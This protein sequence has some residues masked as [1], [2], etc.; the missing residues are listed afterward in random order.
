M[1]DWMNAEYI[2]AFDLLRRDG[3]GY[4]EVQ[5][6]ID[7]VEDRKSRRTGPN[8]EFIG[9]AYFRASEDPASRKWDKGLLLRNAHLR[10][11]AKLVGRNPRNATGAVVRLYVEEDVKAF[12]R[13][14]DLI[15]LRPV[16]PPAGTTP[17]RDREEPVFDDLE[18]HSGV[19]PEDLQPPVADPSPASGIEAPHLRRIVDALA[20]KGVIWGDVCLEMGWP[21]EYQ[22]ADVR[23]S[24]VDEVVE[25]IMAAG[26]AK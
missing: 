26:G 8:T 5:L 19:D 20:D 4:K 21:E 11:I 3:G 16:K 12:G 10:V 1:V 7:R 17:G 13:V 22:V 9:V 14:R 24:E 6:V 18:D 25:A 2:S 23:A 15:R